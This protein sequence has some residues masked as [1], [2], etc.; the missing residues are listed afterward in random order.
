MTKF[1][2]HSL[3][4]GNETNLNKNYVLPF[5]NAHGNYKFGK[6]KSI[7]VNYSYDVDF[8]SASQIL[9]VENL[10]NPLN[11]Y[12][13]N[14]DLD[15]NKTHNLYLSFRDFNMATRSGYSIYVGGNYYDSQVVSSTIFDENRKRTTT[16]DNVSGTYNSW[17]GANWNKTIKNEAHTFKFGL[18]LG[19]NYGLSKGFAN[20]ELFEARSLRMAPRANFTYEYGELLTINPSYNY[21]YNDTKYTNYAMGSASNSVA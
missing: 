1:D 4:L 10:A 15:P 6:S 18:N 9:P 12:I 5:A 8:P 13:G 7:W 17:F 19:A 11:T 20:G 2:N 16:Y 14:P 3:Y 21:T